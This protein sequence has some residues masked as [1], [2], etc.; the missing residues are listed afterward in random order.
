MRS[1]SIYRSLLRLYPA[2]HRKE[3]GEEMIAVFG[4]MQAE[5]A[6]KSLWKGHVFCPR[7]AVALGGALGEHW[8]VWVVILLNCGFLQGGLRCAPNFVF[9]K[10]PPC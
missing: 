9:R 1:I 10:Q 7:D 5:M 4:E 2:S 8:R 3:F 6:S